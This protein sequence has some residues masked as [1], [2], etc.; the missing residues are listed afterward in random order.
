MGFHRDDARARRKER[1]GECSLPRADVEHDA[2]GSDVG[3]SDEP[4]GPLR[5]ELVP[6]PAPPARIHG[7]A[8]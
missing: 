2:A 7:D 3:V 1:S 8:P 6:S 4:S 5:V